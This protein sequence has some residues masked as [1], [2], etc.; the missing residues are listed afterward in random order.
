[1]KALSSRTEEMLFESGWNSLIRDSGTKVSKGN[2]L[3]RFLVSSHMHPLNNKPLA[4]QLILALRLRAH[5]VTNNASCI[6]GSRACLSTS[7]TSWLMLNTALCD[8]IPF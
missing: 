4:C 2:M 8:G 3:T 7:F 5:G 1:M 6:K